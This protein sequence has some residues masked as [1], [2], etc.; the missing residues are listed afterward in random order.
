MKL[1]NLLVGLALLSS[2]TIASAQVKQQPAFSAGAGSTGSYTFGT[3]NFVAVDA[4]GIGIGN[5]G[6]SSGYVQDTP[7]ATYA[8]VTSD[9]A[10]SKFTLWYANSSGQ[11]ITAT[12]TTTSLSVNSTNGLTVGNPVVINH[13]S[14]IVEARILSNATATSS[15]VLTS[16]LFPYT[17]TTNFTYT[18]VVNA[19]PTYA[20]IPG[21]QVFGYSIQGSIPVGSA[22]LT[23]GPAPYVLV[24]QFQ[25]PMLTSIN[26]TSAG[27]I[28]LITGEFK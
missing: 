28:N 9:L 16:A 10:G 23:V 26:F 2:V 4:T 20:A 7:A 3:T 25:T 19:A 15:N 6:A 5:T 18:L 13:A 1:K 22:T 8:S 21:D 11:A 17:V 12:N 27:Q 14:G 24:G